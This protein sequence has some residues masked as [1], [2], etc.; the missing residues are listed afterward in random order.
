MKIRVSCWVAIV[1]V[2]CGATSCAHSAPVVSQTEKLEDL[3]GL[4]TLA[5][6]PEGGDWR[7]AVKQLG[8]IAASDDRLRDKIWAE[9]FVNTLG[10]RF[11]R[12]EPGV[13]TMGPD[14]HR[15]FSSDVAHVV[16]VTAPFYIAVTEVSNAQYKQIFPEFNVDAKYS[17][18][19][20]GPAVNVSWNEADK[21]CKR[22][23][24]RENAVYQ[25]PS[26]AQWEYACRAGTR[27]LYS[28]GSDAS[29][30]S[31]YAWCNHANGRA[32]PVAMLRPNA[33]GL[34]DMHG[35]AFEWVSDWYS[36]GFYSECAALGPVKDPKGPPHGR[37]HVIRGGGWVVDNPLALTSAFRTPLPTFD[38]F[39]FDPDPVGFRQTIGFRVVRLP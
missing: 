27:T 35:N 39:P 24:A 33:W 8:G 4:I 38:R 10:M 16:E 17:P 32:S 19:A 26:E 18:D 5:Q 28:F 29:Q 3:T 12:I 6:S 13:F 31:E 11:V 30:L 14:R 2:V 25:L 21:F 1:P 36:D 22:L 20:D 34:Y 37:V 7:A 15:I 9:A 23:S